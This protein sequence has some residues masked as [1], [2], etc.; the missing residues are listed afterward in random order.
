MLLAASGGTGKSTVAYNWALNIAQGQPWSGRRCMKGKSLIIQSDEPLV[1]TSEKL[2]VIGYQDAELE[3][4]TICFWES[5][6][7]AHM[8]QL[9]DYVRKHRPLF[10]TIDSLTA[11]LAGMNVDLIK[12]NAGDVIYGLRDIANTYRCSIL[13]LH[14]LNKSGGLRDSTSFVDNVSEV[15]KL[16]R[17]EGNFDPNE[18]T[19]EWL[20]SRS[21]LT[22]KHSLQRDSLN[23]G[24]RYT[25]PIGG[26]LEELDQA[27]NTINMRKT[28][29]FNKQQVASLSGSWD[30]ASTG[31][32]LEVARRQGLITSSFQDGPNGE[33]TRMYQSWDYEEPEFDFDPAPQSAPQSA[34]VD[35]DEEDF[36]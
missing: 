15:V 36:F 28:E 4:G 21:G 23:Y 18:F 12:S 11:C 29:R 35:A 1:D 8:K 32:M 25:G 6:R 31:K 17:S 2:G 26:S 34:P 14:H 13:I 3:P 9:E 5:W 33:K 24:W 22:G 16:T 30:V 7:F 10:I 27:V 19:L 20:K